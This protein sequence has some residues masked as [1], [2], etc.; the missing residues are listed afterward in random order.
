MASM[1]YCQFE[2]LNADMQVIVDRYEDGSIEPENMNKDEKNAI[3]D[4]LYSIGD[5]KSILEEISENM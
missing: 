4:L 3:D 1:S 2:N 5:F